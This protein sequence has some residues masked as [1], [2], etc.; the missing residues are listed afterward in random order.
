M[1]HFYTLVRPSS[2][3]SVVAEPEIIEPQFFSIIT[4]LHNRTYHYNNGGCTAISGKKRL[5]KA[6]EN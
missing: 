3:A 5:N 2:K 6:S 4:G 1:A